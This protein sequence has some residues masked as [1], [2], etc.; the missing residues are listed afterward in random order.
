MSLEQ[1]FGKLD[2]RIDRLL[3][4]SEK[5]IGKK[6]AV[7]LREL[8]HKVSDFFSEY[9]DGDDALTLQTMQKYNRLDKFNKEITEIARKSYTPVAREMRKGIRSSLTTS[10]DQTTGAVGEAAGKTIRGTLKPETVNEIVQTPHSGL[11][12][13]ERLQRRRADVVGRIQ[14]TLVRGMNQGERYS[15][16]ANRLKDEL[17]GDARKAERIIRTEGHRVAE[18]GK[19]KA[20]EHAT[21][22][23]VKMKKTWKSSGDERVRGAPG[24]KYPDAIAKHHLMDGQTVDTDEDFYNEYTGGSGPTPGQLGV[25]EDDIF[26]RCLAI[27][28]VVEVE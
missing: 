15:T 17:E 23:G 14:E 18:E 13:N 8:R 6:Y 28:E 22:Q 5:E 4:N 7:M 19:R 21:K 12:L 9:A 11:K 3:N 25:A 1:E 16:M 27:Y 2:N 24:G 20:V 10:F 26:C